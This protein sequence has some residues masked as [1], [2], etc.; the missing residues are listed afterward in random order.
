MEET[1]DNKTGLDILLALR[2]APL[3]QGNI[4]QQTVNKCVKK[5]KKNPLL[6]PGLR[7]Q[8]IRG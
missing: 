3:I 2:I 5:G 4:E 1:A 8:N 7:Q 6:T